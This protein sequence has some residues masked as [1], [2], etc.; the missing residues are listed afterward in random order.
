MVIIQNVTKT[1][2][3]PTVQQ[4]RDSTIIQV[5]CQ[6]SSNFCM[7][8][9]KSKQKQGVNFL[10]KTF[11]LIAI[12]CLSL[13]KKI[14]KWPHFEKVYEPSNLWDEP[15]SLKDK[16]F[17][18][19]FNLQTKTKTNKTKHWKKHWKYTNTQ[20]K[21]YL[22]Q[23]SKL[24]KQKIFGNMNVLSSIYHPIFTIITVWKKI[25]FFENWIFFPYCE[26]SLLFFDIL[27]VQ[28]NVINP[29]I[30]VIAC[31]FAVAVSTIMIRTLDFTT[32]PRLSVFKIF[33]I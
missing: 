11:L 4:L 13:S 28:G 19:F 21:C 17:T 30:N 3:Y 25:Q 18:H 27:F 7:I 29:A 24:Q 22:V 8:D 26:M 9:I 33:I 31:Y 16:M 20:N 6:F 1:P 10:I 2:I 12:F 15:V 14:Q 23:K 32:S 5:L